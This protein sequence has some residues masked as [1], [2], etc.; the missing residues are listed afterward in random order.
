MENT[1]DLE[2]ELQQHTHTDRYLAHRVENYRE[3]A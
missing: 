2:E 3:L 1:V